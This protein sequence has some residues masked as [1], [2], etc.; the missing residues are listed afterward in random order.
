M[1]VFWI[2]YLAMFAMIAAVLTFVGVYA[3]YPD[4]LTKQEQEQL[5]RRIRDVN[6][7]IMERE[8]GIND[9]K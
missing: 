5:A 3:N 6:I 8:L 9:K 7:T 1:I 2:L 4:E